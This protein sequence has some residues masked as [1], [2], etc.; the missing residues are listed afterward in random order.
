MEKAEKY[1][2]M[3]DGERLVSLRK[4]LHRH[5]E[6]GFE[7][8]ETVQIVER[9]LSCLGLSYTERYAPGSVVAEFGPE[10]AG[11]T[12]AL[13]ADMDALPIEEQSEDDCRS[14][15]PGC[16]HA[17]GH[18]AH[19]AMLL[20]AARAL[21]R[22]EAAGELHC[23]VRLLFQPN[24]EGSGS[25]AA[26]MVGNGVMDGVDFVFGQHVDPFFE[27]GTIAFCDGPMEAGCR[28]YNVTFHGKSTHATEPTDGADPLAMAVRAYEGIYLMK[29]R[30]IGPFEDHI[31]SVSALH[32]GSAH[33]IIPD[34][35]SMK[36]S[37]RSY[38]AALDRRIR[39][40]I[41]EICGNSARE[42]GGSVEVSCDAGLPPVVMTKEMNDEG[43]KAAALIVGAD[44]LRI[45]EKCMGSED[46]SYYLTKCPG[47][48]S[49]LG[50]RNE[51]KGYTEQLHNCRFH[52]D[53]DALLTGAVYLA[54]LVLNYSNQGGK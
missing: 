41:E 13:R 53:D 51:E 23:R 49:L 12:L 25:G 22:A 18:D 26:V 17:C 9:E 28:S 24:E 37:V 8:K 21:R 43:R 10:D 39:E 50:I 2:I 7:L 52:V 34:L 3:E 46:F 29:C 33:N 4:E 42:F 16:M 5:P 48:F 27:T 1:F 6:I 20:T 14:E 47:I 45:A 36:I 31:V 15:N 54:Q 35:A 38:D 40:K 11:L 19:T 44:K 32:A 30:M